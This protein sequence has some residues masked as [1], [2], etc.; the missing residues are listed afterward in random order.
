MTSAPRAPRGLWTLR[1]RRALF[2][3]TLGLIVATA[4][5]PRRA[6]VPFGFTA[7][8]AAR[9]LSIERQ[10]LDFPSADRIRETHRHLT[11][12][13]HIAGSDRDRVLAE[14]V[15]DQFVAAGL[16]TAEITIH[17][18]LLPWPEEATVEMTAPRAWRAAMREEALS[19]DPYTRVPIDHTGLPYHAYSASGDVMAP[20]VYAGRGTPAEYDRLAMQGIDVRGKIAI[21]RHSVPYSYRGFKVMTAEQRG[22]AGILIYSDP[23]D[24]GYGRGSMY[25]EGPWGHESAIQR[26]GVVYDFLV[27]GDPLTPGFAS[28]PGGR[29]VPSS[30]AISLPR[31]VS[32]PL[33]SR[34]ARVILEAIG[35]P[36]A[37]ETWRGGMPITYRLGGDAAVVRMRVRCDDRI[38]PI[39]TVTG[40]IR[41]AERPDELVIIG[42]HRDAWVYGGVDP[43]SGSAALIELA[44]A[45]GRLA[46]GGWRP[47]RS[48]LF[49]S[50]DAEEFALISSTEWGEQHATALQRNAVA[51]LNVDSGVSGPSF[52]AAAVPPL[53]RVLVEAATTVRDPIARIP[54]AAVSR[55][56]RQRGALPTVGGS[57]LVNNRVGGGSDYT[58]FLNFLGIPVADL[59]FEGPYGVYHSIYDTHNWVARIGDPGFKYHVALTQLWGIAAMR[60][61]AADALPLDYEPYAARIAEF[62]RELE[63]SWASIEP[64]AAPDLDIITAAAKDLQSAAGD[65]NSA[66]DSALARNDTSAI[67]L[68]NARLL[69]TERALIHP[70]G[71]AGRPWYRH[72]IYAPKFTYAPE[73]LPGVAEAIQRGDRQQVRHEAQ[74]LAGAIRHAADQLA[75]RGEG[76]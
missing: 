64:G 2:G 29:R 25:P 74:R 28:V 67:A 70:D 63:R 72:L 43:S 17:E 53:N 8:S 5:W 51:Y 14:W 61:A 46:R 71:L 55:E 76:E 40:L 35:G 15:R 62:V 24:T 34:D 49:A 47:K 58:V 59:T 60:L 41:G 32:A 48:I 57:E 7:A 11:E 19:D 44:H 16:D 69:R 30:R 33:S 31:I 45:F 56:R 6:Q 1:M 23:A 36:E 39:W 66:R 50:W 27:P 65:F 3:V 13:P 54:V 4:A 75:G 52:A 73:V 26:G 20:A 18:V 9:H 68:L 38:R 37:P 10:F 21:V 22:L 42:N 12:K